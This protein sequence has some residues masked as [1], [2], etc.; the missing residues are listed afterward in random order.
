MTEAPDTVDLALAL[1]DITR[2]WRIV[3]A[4]IAT[5][6]LLSAGVLAVGPRRFQ[7]D[8]SAIVRNLPEGGGSMLAKL[9]DGGGGSAASALLGGGIS[10]P[11]ETDVQ[12][13]QSRAVIGSVVD[14]LGLQ[15]EVRRPRGLAALSVVRAV[16]MPGGF[17]HRDVEGER[18]SDGRYR[19]SEGGVSVFAAPGMSVRLPV[20]TLRLS[21]DAPA[22]FRL[23]VYDREEAIAR[24]AKAV[25]ISKAG[26][27][28]L[29]VSFRATDSLTAARV[30]NAF[31]LTYLSRKRTSDR[32]VNAHRAE[33]LQ[34]Q[35][36]STADQLAQAENLL[37]SF[38]ERSGV[39][40]APAIGKLAL[41]Q[42][43]DLR[44]GAATLEVEQGALD[45]LLAQVAAGAIAP[46]QLAAYPSLL[47]S[48]GVNELLAQLSQLE[49]ER[50][51]LLERR[52]E[53]DDAVVALD[54]SI[55]QLEGQLV[56]L[57]SSYATSLRR[58]RADVNRQLAGVVGGLGAFPAEAQSSFRLT[59]EVLRLS[60]VL[61]ALQTQ[62]VQARVAVISEGGD[63]RAL[64]IA[65]PPLEVSFPRPASTLAVGL[66]GG[67]IVG[68]ILALLMGS[69][70]RYLLGDDAIQRAFDIPVLRFSPGQP[71]V[72]SRQEARP[73]VVL[74]VALDE[75][76][77]TMAVANG[78]FD[79][80][81]ARGMSATV[82]DFGN[83]GDAPRGPGHNADL[84]RRLEGE[85][86][87]VIVSTPRLASA[88]TVAVLRED[89]PVLL[90]ACAERV[91]R[92]ELGGAV[93]MLNQ[94]GI[95]CAG[96]VINTSTRLELTASP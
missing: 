89:R 8:A 95:T 47:R 51:K 57:A 87:L 82:V 66:G 52:L 2:R 34:Q 88:A 63:V 4:A 35:I 96:V 42:A 13:L 6:G 43:A 78:I 75:G 71:L 31:L 1:R 76:A 14:S 16:T 48:A 86:D 29:R 46:R 64:D 37:R 36:D 12:I 55:S 62:L 24:T 73:S 22:T 49:T 40:D 45:Q 41:E 11:L 19:L 81:L 15:V 53:S 61:T 83:E 92:A 33:F 93:S 77:R 26:G 70:G 80:A 23:R 30:P 91:G 65:Q 18:Q 85:H 60:A 54:R 25:A 38:Q 28:V 21:P 20:G 39:I 17:R 58:Q 59:R 79:T 3:A 56:P 72:F 27:E 67:L 10:S 32:G 5:G 7:A 94:L 44:K 50:A 90:V 74:V 68:I 69:H 9:A 84:V